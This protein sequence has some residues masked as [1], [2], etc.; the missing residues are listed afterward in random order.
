MRFLFVHANYTQYL[1]KYKFYKQILQMTN[2][3]I[4]LFHVNVWKKSL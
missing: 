2:H 4:I 3:P 1:Q